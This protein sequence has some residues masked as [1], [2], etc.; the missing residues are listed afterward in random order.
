MSTRQS[1]GSNVPVVVLEIMQVRE[2]MCWTESGGV[3]RMQSITDPA[4][5]PTE[6]DTHPRRIEILDVAESN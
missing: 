4:P 3:L 2:R 5:E 1:S 6:R